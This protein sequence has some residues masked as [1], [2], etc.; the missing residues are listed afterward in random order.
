MTETSPLGTIFSL[1]KGMEDYSD[2][3][4][5][6]LQCLQGRGVFGIE[7]C[8]VDENN[9]ELQAAMLN[10]GLEEVDICGLLSLP[11]LNIDTRV[12]ISRQ[13]GAILTDR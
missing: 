13:S 12:V 7:M 2:E 10:K 1:K 6:D 11:A 8:I 5:T 3:Q 9:E 4:M